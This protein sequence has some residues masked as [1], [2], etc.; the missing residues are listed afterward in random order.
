MFRKDPVIETMN[1]DLPKVEGLPHQEEISEIKQDEKGGK[2]NKKNK[3]GKKMS[4]E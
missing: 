4:E 1:H 2:K 3:K